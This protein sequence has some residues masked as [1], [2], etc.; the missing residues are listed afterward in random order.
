MERV[1]AEMASVRSPVE[2]AGEWNSLRIST[3]GMA[4]LVLHGVL[5]SLWAARARARPTRS[6]EGRA[7][8]ASFSSAELISIVHTERQE[9]GR[10]DEL[11]ALKSNG[12][13]QR[14]VLCRNRKVWS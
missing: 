3:R 12:R 5:A 10:R 9:F 14:F 7:E 8:L 4:A 2:V 1:P 13:T 6:R 11:A